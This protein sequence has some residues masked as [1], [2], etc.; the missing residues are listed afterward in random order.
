M[1]LNELIRS[2]YKY[3]DRYRQAHEMFV[4]YRTIYTSQFRYLNIWSHPFLDEKLILPD[5]TFKIC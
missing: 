4:F 2:Q 1:E 3:F 5:D